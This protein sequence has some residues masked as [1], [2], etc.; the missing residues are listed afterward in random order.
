[1]AERQQQHAMGP[2]GHCIC[3]SCGMDVPHRRGTHCQDERCPNCGAKMLR[4]GS[5]HHQLWRAKTG[6]PLADKEG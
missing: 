1:M 6:V 3:P 5:H 2:G 4:Q